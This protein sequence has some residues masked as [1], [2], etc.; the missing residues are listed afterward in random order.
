M[1]FGG[2]DHKVYLGFL[3]CSEYATDSVFNQYGTYGSQYSATSIFNH[4]NEY[5]SAYSAEGAC[6][7]YASDPPVIVDGNGRYYLRLTLN[8]YARDLGIGTRFMGW[9]A[10]ICER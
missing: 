9:L 10:A 6:N 1:I 3:N 4:Y 5:G 2:V 7:K 8:E